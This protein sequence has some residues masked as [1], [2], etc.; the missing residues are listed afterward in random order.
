MTNTRIVLFAIAVSLMLFSG[1]TS[2][3]GTEGSN[4]P[5]ENVTKEVSSCASSDMGFGIGKLPCCGA[6]AAEGGK[7]TNLV[8]LDPGTNYTRASP[9]NSKEA[10]SIDGGTCTNI[11]LDKA[12]A[13]NPTKTELMEN[14]TINLC[15][16]FAKSVCMENC[17]TG[18]FRAISVN[19]NPGLSPGDIHQ[20]KLIYWDNATQISNHTNDNSLSVARQN[21]LYS[22]GSY[23]MIDD[24]VANDLKGK[25]AMDIFRF[26]VGNTF[27][28]FDEAQVL[29]PFSTEEI[30]EVSQSGVE[31]F[32]L[33]YYPKDAIRNCV[34]DK[35][36]YGYKCNNAS[37]ANA[38]GKVFPTFESCLLNC[39]GNSESLRP[40][41]IE[42]LS[43]I[44]RNRPAGKDAFV[45]SFYVQNAS[46]LN[47][48]SSR[49]V[50]SLSQIGNYIGS[51]AAWQP[52]VRKNVSGYLLD[53][54]G[55]FG[56]S[57]TITTDN[58]SFSNATRSLPQL[59]SLANVYYQV[60]DMKGGYSDMMSRYDSSTYNYS[61]S[62][63]D[64]KEKP[65]LPF[66]CS[67]QDCKSGIC[68][69]DT[70]Y[71]TGCIGTA[72]ANADVKCGCD[73]LGC[74]QGSQT[75]ANF[76]KTKLAYYEA[77]NCSASGMHAG[78]GRGSNYPIPISENNSAKSE[79]LTKTVMSSDKQYMAIP[80]DF[81]FY[82][83][84]V[85]NASVCS[86]LN[87]ET[88][89]YSETP[90]VGCYWWTMIYWADGG[91][92]PNACDRP[93]FFFYD[94]C[95]KPAYTN[96]N[97]APGVSW[98]Y[99]SNWATASDGASSQLFGYMFDLG[100]RGCK[101]DDRDYSVQYQY[102]EL[103]DRLIQD[104][105]NYYYDSSLF[106]NLP[107]VKS[108][109]MDEN[110]E[111]YVCVNP[112]VLNSGGNIMKA[113]EGANGDHAGRIYGCRLVQSISGLTIA[114]GTGMA[115]SK[116]PTIA[117]SRLT[118]ATC[119]W[120]E[121]YAF[122][123]SGTVYANSDPSYST[124]QI[125][126]S[127]TKGVCENLTQGDFCLETGA[128]GKCAKEA[129][130]MVLLNP[131]PDKKY[132]NCTASNGA[133]PD[134]RQYG[135][136]ENPSYVNLAVQVIAPDNLYFPNDTANLGYIPA[137]QSTNV[138][139]VV[140]KRGGVV[141]IGA[142]N[143]YICYLFG[144]G[145]SVCSDGGY[146]YM[147]GDEGTPYE[148]GNA[149]AVAVS[150]EE[151]PAHTCY[152]LSNGN[153]TCYGSHYYSP[154]EST[155]YI[156]GNAV[157]VSAGTDDTCYVL[158][159]G[160]GK[161]YGSHGN[162]WNYTN[163]GQNAIA[164]SINSN[165]AC[166][167]L[168][169]GNSKCYGSGAATASYA[170][171]NAIAVSAGTDDTCYV[172]SDGNGKCYGSHGNS[173]NYTNTGNAAIA[174]SVS[175]NK[176]CYLLSN[177]NSQC[178]GYTGYEDYG[179]PSG[180]AG[181]DAVAVY[182]SYY[183]TCYLLSNSSVK[184]YGT[185]DY[186]YN[187]VPQPGPTTVLAAY[188]T[189][190]KGSRVPFS[191]LPNVNGDP[192]SASANFW[193]PLD[194]LRNKTRSYLQSGISVMLFAEHPDLYNYCGSD[195]AGAYCKNDSSPPFVSK[196]LNDIY[197]KSNAQTFVP[198]G[199]AIVVTGRATPVKQE[200]TEIKFSTAEPGLDYCHYYKDEGRYNSTYYATTEDLAKR[201][202]QVKDM[203]PGCRTA[204]EIA[205]NLRDTGSGFVVETQGNDE[206][207]MLQMTFKR[208]VV[209]VNLTDI[210][211]KYGLLPA[212]RP[213]P[214]PGT[215]CQSGA[216]FGPGNIAALTANCGAGYRALETSTKRY[217]EGLKST[218]SKTYYTTAG[219]PYTLPSPNNTI[220]TVSGTG[221]YTTAREQQEACSTIKDSA[222]GK[223]YCSISS[224]NALEYFDFV[225]DLTVFYTVQLSRPYNGWH[226]IL[227]DQG[228]DTT[229]HVAG[230]G[231]VT[232]PAELKAAGVTVH[233]VTCDCYT[234]G[235]STS[236]TDWTS[237]S[238]AG[239][240]LQLPHNEMSCSAPTC[241]ADPVATI[242]ETCTA[243]PNCVNVPSFR[244]AGTCSWAPMPETG[245]NSCVPSGGSTRV[246]RWGAMQVNC[247]A[248]LYPADFIAYYKPA[249]Q[250]DAALAQLE[251][252]IR[253]DNTANNA[254]INAGVCTRDSDIR[255]FYVDG[256][257]ACNGL[258]NSTDMLVLNLEIDPTPTTAGYGAANYEAWY[259]AMADAIVNYSSGETYT[260]G[261]PIVLY[262]R[263][264]KNAPGFDPTKFMEV[265]GLNMERMT[266]AG[267]VAI[268]FEDWKKATIDDV[269]AYT[270]D[271]TDYGNLLYPFNASGAPTSTFSALSE[272]G[273]A[274]S[275][276]INFPVPKP[277]PVYDESTCLNSTLPCIADSACITLDDIKTKRSDGTYMN[278]TCYNGTG[279]I[280]IT[281]ALSNPSVEDIA[282]VFADPDKYRNLISSVNRYSNWKICNSSVENS[283]YFMSYMSNP[284][285]GIPV[286]WDQL[287]AQNC[288]ASG[289]TNAEMLSFVSGGATDYVCRLG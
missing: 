247:D 144:N 289:L 195:S 137:S 107:I 163:T 274:I 191:I 288:T 58:L 16:T 140:G 160:N 84:L 54:F 196:L 37:S 94:G 133:T 167:L 220:I 246:E 264:L 49:R 192:K 242:G 1:C 76:S 8:Q 221:S 109:G 175:E 53:E 284:G 145:T 6:I 55:S 241:A 172:L 30:G 240:N 116:T 105:Q 251:A 40:S 207:D 187:P 81:G 233:D 39:A 29:L 168:A 286:A 85:D 263:D 252:E 188:A 271:Q 143:D 228:C 189:D 132:G 34:M 20:L 253:A 43:M 178:Y 112:A 269:N 237:V 213:G 225:P 209:Q 64:G 74:Y 15:P 24:R 170:G 11:N 65:G 193:P 184:C 96:R 25:A 21:L 176:V 210:Y 212:Q 13:T 68:G 5:L 88:D 230:W 173:W 138:I 249:Y 239:M 234:S 155:S 152:L 215:I 257:E 44:M 22:E 102:I 204:I 33:Y 148:G 23:Q 158:S 190:P 62:L 156:G 236:Y 38:Y 104:L 12:N 123:N 103:G 14:K 93:M 203:C 60:A 141:G 87:V 235:S 92:K 114:E 69:F 86:S 244:T 245:C 95:T 243:K 3:Y 276:K 157:A 226:G 135:M 2:I 117:S 59:N 211:S 254:G 206:G 115:D 205:G 161:C 149:I 48:P 270:T 90:G 77:D 10:C 267:I 75:G 26:G 238:L 80:L 179:G 19:E 7:C 216:A 46:S 261:K 183:Y 129:L 182:T 181:G 70:H 262:I 255:T 125:Q 164:V 45:E 278:I 275:K 121:T 162:S 61:F 18:V 99:D 124:Y 32:A 142:G 217:G 169:D 67:K 73:G 185:Y 219:G 147:T 265:L 72:D 97:I 127:G 106:R 126:I 83:T 9:E 27:A 51:T 280:K 231:D 218:V 287:Q 82:P 154:S 57:F 35:A 197:N 266:N 119:T 28:E 258:F 4:S 208:N 41:G 150:Q 136:C 134:V 63:V 151:S 256:A 171:G 146:S 165:D 130:T 180:Y 268:Q 50:P 79:S 281:Y 260:Y 282:Q 198:V 111:H 122:M 131:G 229:H 202:K 89:T 248:T 186:Y 42:A 177:G 166:Y 153:S 222:A 199:S 285:Y 98:Y 17:T 128:N 194:Y 139:S 118:S 110:D 224:V 174:V 159:D 113:F 250:S 78:F 272:L 101:D 71:R 52:V 214:S 201:N 200:C 36:D 232:C 108:C 66:E 91:K 227:N 259:T 31:S 100:G 279:A 56:D 47:P 283:T 273:K 223:D 120:P 277:T